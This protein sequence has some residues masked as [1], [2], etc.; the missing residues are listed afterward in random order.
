[1]HLQYWIDICISWKAICAGTAFLTGHLET[2]GSMRHSRH[3]PGFTI[4]EL[5]IVLAVVGVMTALAMPSL[6]SG[7]TRAE[8]GV[9]V[10]VSSLLQAQRM[11]VT[12]QRNTVVAFDSARGLI[13]I[14]QDLDNDGRIES[15]ERQLLVELGED[16]VFGVGPASPRSGETG[17]VTF[18]GEQDGL[19]AVT[20]MRNGGMT[21][22]GAVYVT[23]AESVDRPERAGDARLITVERATGRTSWF[24]YENGQWVRGG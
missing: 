2:Q 20:F 23:T 14:H 4:V 10:V 18:D 13:R 6:G 1:M 9:Q 15:G 12:S 16:L 8:S 22:A 3:R 7:K 24:R 11:A 19:P 21:Q 17:P 5:L